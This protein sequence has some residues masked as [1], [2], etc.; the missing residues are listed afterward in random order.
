MRNF[1]HLIR[2]HSEAPT[3]PLVRPLALVTDSQFTPLVTGKWQLTSD[4]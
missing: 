2:G 3:R 4:Q 1:S